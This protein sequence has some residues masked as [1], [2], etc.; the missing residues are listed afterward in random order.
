MASKR[1]RRGQRI[2]SAPKLELAQWDEE[3][4]RGQRIVSARKLA[5]WDE[6]R[7]RRFE[8]DQRRKHDW[9]SFV[10]IAEWYS[11]LGGPVSPKKAAALREQAYRMLESDLLPRRFEEGGPSQVLFLF[12][13]VDWTHGKMTSQR[14]QDAIHYNLDLEHGRSLLRHCWLPRNLFK[15]WC[16]WHDLPTSAP[17]FKPQKSHRVLAPTVRDETAAIKALASHLKSNPESKRG[18]AASWCRKAGFKLT[19]RGFQNRVWP[20]ARVQA[21]LEAKARPGRKR[22]SLR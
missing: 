15:Q 14:Y 12:P 8:E 4:R 17:R 6:E 19:D 18:E 11:E 9:I 7:I 21:G 22:K 2:V 3:S 13:G 5:Q 1:S 16:A 20:K 10:K